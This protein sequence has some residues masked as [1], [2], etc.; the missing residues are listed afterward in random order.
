[1]RLLLILGSPVTAEDV[2]GEVG[3][4]HEVIV[5]PDGPEIAENI[6]AAF[7]ENSQ[8]PPVIVLPCPREPGDLTRIVAALDEFRDSASRHSTTPLTERER[9]VLRLVARGLSNREVA[10]ELGVSESTVKSHVSRV[11]GKLRLRRRTQLAAIAH[12]LGVG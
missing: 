2:R 5:I 11:L 9:S 8:L 1:M 6:R 4:E 7:P 10:V 12:D 3:H